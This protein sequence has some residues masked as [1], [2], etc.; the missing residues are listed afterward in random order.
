MGPGANVKGMASISI[1]IWSLARAQEQI[2][3][4]FPPPVSTPFQWIISFS[5]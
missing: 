1:P 2:L 5:F 3:V 4:G